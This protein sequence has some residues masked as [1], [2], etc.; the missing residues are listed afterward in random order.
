MKEPKLIRE[1]TLDGFTGDSNMLDPANW[2][3][4]SASAGGVDVPGYLETQPGAAG[5]EFWVE[6]VDDSGLEITPAGSYS[7]RVVEKY[8][9]DQSATVQQDRTMGGAT[10]TGAGVGLVQ[11]H[12][13]ES[14][15]VSRG[16]RKVTVQVTSAFAS[17]PI[18]GETKAQVWARSV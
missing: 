4:S 1:I 11:E 14:K 18:A 13:K 17:L 9:D 10:Q 15:G 8:G 2:P 7:Y 6:L 16:P 3:T 12:V 5:F